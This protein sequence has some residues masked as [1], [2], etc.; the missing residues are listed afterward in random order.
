MTKS[1][2]V[3]ES[4]W[5]ET[6]KT[7]CQWNITSNLKMLQFLILREVEVRVMRNFASCKNQER[8]FFL[9]NGNLIQGQAL[10][11]CPE[12]MKML[13]NEFT[14]SS[15]LNPNRILDHLD[16]ILLLNLR[17]LK[18]NQDNLNSIKKGKLR[19]S[20]CEILTAR[21]RFL[22]IICR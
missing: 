2:I 13:E 21:S 12:Q 5:R 19:S 15:L 22:G 1:L 11:L 18:A 10:K 4:I 9:R 7:M 17:M 3:H 8:S 16:T 6:M 20:L 14:Q